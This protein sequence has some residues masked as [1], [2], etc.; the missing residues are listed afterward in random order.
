MRFSLLNNFCSKDFDRN[1]GSY[2]SFKASFIVV[3]LKVGA[4]MNF[5]KFSNIKFNESQL[6]YCRGITCGLMDGQTVTAE[7]MAAL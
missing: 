7:L 5:I 1:L 2:S 4:S 6:I 3:R